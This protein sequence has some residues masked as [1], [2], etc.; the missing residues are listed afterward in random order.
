MMRDAREDSAARQTQKR[1]KTADTR[2]LR[3]H[4]RCARLR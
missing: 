2:L 3:K 1:R 4:A